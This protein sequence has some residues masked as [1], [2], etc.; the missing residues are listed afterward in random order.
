M[1]KSS[2]KNMTID[3]ILLMIYVINCIFLM[4]EL[5]FVMFFDNHYWICVGLLL[6]LI[7]VLLFRK[8]SNKAGYIWMRRIVILLIDVLMVVCNILIWNTQKMVQDE[9]ML[10]AIERV[11]VLSYEEPYESLDELAGLSVGVLRE[12]EDLNQQIFDKFDSN[13]LQCDIVYV[14][15]YSQLVHELEQGE[16]QVALVDDLSLSIMRN[17]YPDSMAK[18]QIVYQFKETTAIKLEQ[19]DKDVLSEPFSILISGIDEVGSSEVN[20]KSGFNL[21][22]FVDPNQSR[23]S[24]VVLNEDSY[25]PNPDYD[26]YPDRLSHIGYQGVESIMKSIE[27]TFDIEIDYFMKFSHTSLMELIRLLKGIQEQLVEQY[28]KVLDCP[29]E[30]DLA[31][32]VE[33]IDSSDE[34]VQQAIQMS[35]VESFITYFEEQKEALS[36][37]EIMHRLD[38]SYSSNFEISKLKEF[39]DFA[40][41]RDWQ[42]EVFSLKSGH[43]ANYPCISWDIDVDL[44]VYIL[45][46]QDIALVKELYHE[47]VV[48]NGWADFGFDLRSAGLL[49][50]A[51]PSYVIYGENSDEQVR[52]LFSLL[53]VLFIEELHLNHDK[54]VVS[55]K[56]SNLR[57]DEAIQQADSLQ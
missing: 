41:Q 13:D 39:A 29:S 38:G 5:Y 21:L 42:V 49:S 1:E 27:H 40:K 16:I 2:S 30:V 28:C 52:Q 17:M 33:L 14:E 20:A 15:T 54:P 4:L 22:V 57:L 24:M 26:N 9:S 6:L 10:T 19:S 43:Y 8:I 31:T 32:I 45:S 7:F 18:L 47:V 51:L 3:L 25:M 50:E 34:Y 23:L 36:F 35:M 48:Q 56:E 44:L 55:L 46:L 12:N 53:P 37:E 11:N